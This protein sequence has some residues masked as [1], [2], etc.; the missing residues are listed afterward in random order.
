MSIQNPV[1]DKT[2]AGFLSGYSTILAVG[3]PAMGKLP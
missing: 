3:S 1:S 2:G